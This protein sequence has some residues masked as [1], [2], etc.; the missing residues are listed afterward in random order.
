MI[1]DRIE[2]AA[3]DFPERIAVHSL[4]GEMTYGDLWD[5]SDRLAS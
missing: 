2:K 3:G 5:K 1:L 4:Q